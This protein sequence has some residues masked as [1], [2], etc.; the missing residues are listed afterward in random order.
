MLSRKKNKKHYLFWLIITTALAVMSTMVTISLICELFPTLVQLINP[1]DEF[2]KVL[3]IFM[4]PAVAILNVIPIGVSIVFWIIAVWRYYKY[5]RYITSEGE[6]N[7]DEINR[8]A[9]R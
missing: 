2:T 6:N 9:T 5:K 7:Y 1:A 3:A 8:K 4:F